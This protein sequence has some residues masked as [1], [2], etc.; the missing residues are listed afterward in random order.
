MQSL[1]NVCEAGSYRAAAKDVSLNTIRTR[2]AELERKIGTPLVKA[3]IT[4]VVPTDAGLLLI[5][6]AKAMRTALE[7][8]LEQG[9]QIP[10]D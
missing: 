9:F 10:R 8:G 5:Q 2:V 6:T 3:S 1:L 4:G 7:E